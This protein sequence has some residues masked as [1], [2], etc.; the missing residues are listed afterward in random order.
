MEIYQD[1]KRTPSERA[2]DLL[3]KMSLEEKMGQIV[4][5]W[6]RKGEE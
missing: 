2:K 1:T 4:G 3:D 5:A 6:A